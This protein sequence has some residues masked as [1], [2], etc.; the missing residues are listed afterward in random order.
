MKINSINKIIWKK[1][2]DRTSSLLAL[3]FIALCCFLAIFTYQ[4]I[5]DKTP[6]ANEMNLELATLPPFSKVQFLSTDILCSQSPNSIKSFFFGKLNNCKMIPVQS[7]SE[8]KDGCIYTK[9]N[10][11][12]EYKFI[13]EYKFETRNFWLGTD[14]FGRD[15]FSRL[16]YGIRVSLSI[17]LVAVFI[18]VL[19]GL[20]LGLLAGYFRGRTD[21]IIMWFINV[22]WS[23]PTLLMVIAIT[24]ALGKGFWQVFIAVGLTMWVE[25]ARIVRGQ[26]LAVRELEYVQAAQVLGY[27]SFRILKQHILPNIIGPVIV[28]SAANF[29]SAILIEAGLSFLGIGAQP[30]FPS[31]GGIIKDHYSYIVMN[32]AYLAIFPG[33]AIMLLVLS[34]MILGNGIRDAFDVKY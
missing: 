12:V 7:F 27:K 28:I 16:I 19:I 20:T 34:F 21:D 23:I 5:P 31:W 17:G 9:Y 30:P 2:K 4:I 8:I 26:V 24:L 18:S 25:V 11:L 33:V 6:M 10:S 3:F 15:F 29:A 22:V 14:K 1:F 32:K 13:G